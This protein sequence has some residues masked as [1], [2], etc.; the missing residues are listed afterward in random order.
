MSARVDATLAALADARAKRQQRPPTLFDPRA[1]PDEPPTARPEATAMR[2][3]ERNA[4]RAWSNHVLD[5]TRRVATTSAELTVDD[6]TPHIAEPVHDTRALGPVMR[7]AARL[8]YIRPTG[9]YRTS[10]R[11]ETHS[12]PLRVWASCITEGRA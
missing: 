10:E 8:G 5:V 6:I 1:L 2:S 3:V 7:R 12:R 11:P 4:G 9:Q